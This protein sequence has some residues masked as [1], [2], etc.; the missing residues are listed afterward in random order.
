MAESQNQNA[1]KPETVGL[2]NHT[3]RIFHLMPKGKTAPM[4]VMPGLN[5]AD[6]KDWEAVK[7]SK[8]VK[9]LLADHQLEVYAGEP[10]IKDMTIAKA[11][12]LV[13]VTLDRA[14]LRKWSVEETRPSVAKAI[15][16]QLEK[17][18]GSK[19]AA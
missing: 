13:A 10:E 14:I 12:E 16:A 1:K 7:D 19:K 17:V 18:D 4:R 15:D 2:I 9:H 3:A 6:P 5:R 11:K 8:L